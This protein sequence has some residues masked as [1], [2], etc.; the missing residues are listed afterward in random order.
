[1]QQSA[2]SAAGKHLPGEGA[3]VGMM[4]RE[5]S[6]RIGAGAGTVKGL[7]MGPENVG[8]LSGEPVTKSAM[9]EVSR[10]PTSG[11]WMVDRDAGMS[12]PA[13]QE[14]ARLLEL[15]LYFAGS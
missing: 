2:L 15:R 1:M 5:G 7:V 10:R 14:N 8:S 12:G 11:S 6:S 4:G 3:M 13:K 9:S